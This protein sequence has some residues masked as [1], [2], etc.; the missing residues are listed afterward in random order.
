MTN[1]HARFDQIENDERDVGLS[2][3]QKQR[4]AIARALPKKAHAYN[5]AE[6]RREV[7][8]HYATVSRIIKTEE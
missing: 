3:G 6:I 2:G 1:P 8:L 7:G 4:I 5:L